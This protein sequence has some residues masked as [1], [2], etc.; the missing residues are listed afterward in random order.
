M[1]LNA[2]LRLN[3]SGFTSPL[4]GVRGALSSTLGRIAALAGGVLSVRAAFDGLKSALDLGGK[5]SDESAITGIPVRDLVILRQ[6]FE[7]TGVG[8]ESVTR[9]FSTMQR[10][11]GGVNEEGQPTNKFFAQ[12]GLSMAQ[13]SAQSPAEQ[14]ETLQKAITSI[15]DPAQQTAAAMGIFGRGAANLKSFF[16]DPEAI[17]TARRALGALPDTMQRNAA[18]FDK[19]SDSMGR[20]KMKFMGLWAG[21]AESLLPLLNRLGEWIDRIDLSSI[22]RRLGDAIAVAFEAFR[23]GQIAELVSLSLMTAFGKVVNFIVATLGSGSFWVGIAKL[24]TGTLGAA[25]AGL[26]TL[27]LGWIPGVERALS[28]MATRSLEMMGQSIQDISKA[29]FPPPPEDGQPETARPQ[30]IRTQ[31]WEDRLGE[32]F[33]DLKSKLDSQRR[34]LQGAGTTGAAERGGAQNDLATSGPKAE[35][36]TPLNF[37]SFASVGAYSVSPAALTNPLVD[38]NRR[39]A[40]ATERTAKLQGNLLLVMQRSIMLGGAAPVWGGA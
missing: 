11:I 2:V 7:D 17:N 12:L 22:G 8:A 36:L 15:K 25:L 37:G 1:L 35:K 13:L 26:G 39:T 6:A 10:A 20:I 21:A 28:T 29:M 16:A 31:E 23:S 38:Y 9:I 34:E 33:G 4:A 14:F 30:L 24:V 18:I 40:Q 32:I 5:L 3:T 19:I 27:L